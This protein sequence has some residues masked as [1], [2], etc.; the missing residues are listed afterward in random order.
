MAAEAIT[1]RDY[2]L[3]QAYVIWMA[4]IYMLI[5]LIIDILYRYFDPRI[6]LEGEE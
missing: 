6:R 5:N 2:F 3:M 4:I 1:N